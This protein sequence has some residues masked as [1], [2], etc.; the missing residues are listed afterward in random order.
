M[1]IVRFFL[2]NLTLKIGAVLLAVILYGAMVALQ[3]TQ[4]WPGTIAIE[5]VNQPANASLVDAQSIPPVQDIKYI[6][7]ADV[8]VSQSLFRATV[9][10]SNA[11][12]S[13]SDSLLV[14]VKLVAEDPRIQIIDYQPQQ[15]AIKLEPIIHETVAVVVDKVAVPSGLEPGTPV[16]TPP[17]VDVSGASSIV[18]SVAYAQASVRIDASGLDVNTDVD[19][20][21][22]D[23]SNNQVNNVTLNPR[24]VHVQMLI[25]S[26][27]RTETV[28]V[29]PTITGTPAAGYFVTAIDVNPLAAAVSGQADA[30]AALNGKAG[31]QPISVAGATGDVTKTVNL[32]LPSGVASAVGPITV[33]V[34]LSSPPT[35]RSVSV[36]VVPL[37]ARTDR[38]YNLST[39]SVIVTL[40]GATAALN[41]FDTST[42]VATVSVGTLDAGAHTLTLT[43]TVPPGIQVVTISPFSVVVTVTVPPSPLPSASP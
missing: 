15:K 29:D 1:R 20:V 17:T 4:Q 2:G 41:A 7:P 36:G 24:T 14:R 40:G 34:H 21:A 42:L 32:V 39:P 18:R 43:I 28:P 12:P 5:L 3:S 37:G 33:T 23:A 35:T 31:T 38:I 9:D 26:Q 16:V 8:P 19:L 6:A 30:L 27:I 10:L 13:E 22:R 11:K 25:G